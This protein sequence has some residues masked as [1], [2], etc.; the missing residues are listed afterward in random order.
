MYLELTVYNEVLAPIDISD[1]ELRQ[2]V[3]G[4]FSETTE[5]YGFENFTTTFFNHLLERRMGLPLKP[6]VTYSNCRFSPVDISRI[7]EVLWDLIIERYLTVGAGD[8]HE[9]PAFS[10]TKKGRAYFLEH[11]RL[12]IVK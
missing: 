7:R 12:G 5:Q 4:Q 3:I 9:W 6:G 10:V 1:T 2:Q 11:N 8:R